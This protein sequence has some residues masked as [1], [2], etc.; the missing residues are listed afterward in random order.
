MWEQSVG[1]GVKK[2]GFGGVG[3]SQC[4]G[5]S[6]VGVGVGKEDLGVFGLI[7]A[8]DFGGKKW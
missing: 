4:H 1:C 8:L 7:T 3:V 5:G 6:W 2:G